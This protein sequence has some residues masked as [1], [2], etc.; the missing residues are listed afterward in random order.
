[1]NP[2]KGF[3]GHKGIAIFCKILQPITHFYTWTSKIMDPAE[4]LTPCVGFYILLKLNIIWVK[5]NRI[6]LIKSG[7]SI[8][9]YNFYNY[10]YS[11][12][13]TITRSYTRKSIALEKGGIK[14][15]FIL[16][17]KRTFFTCNPTTINKL[18]RL[19]SELKL[20]EFS[21]ISVKYS[22]LNNIS[23]N[24]DKK[25]IKVS[26]FLCNTAFL[27]EINEDLYKKRLI[28]YRLK[29]S[30]VSNIIDN[31]N[32]GKYN[33]SS[34]KS[35]DNDNIIGD[36]IIIEG[37][38]VILIFILEKFNNNIKSFYSFRFSEMNYLNRNLCLS[39][40]K[41]EWNDI[42]WILNYEYIKDFKMIHRKI[43]FSELEK[44][45]QDQKFFDILHKLFNSK[46]FGIS[47]NNSF[48]KYLFSNQDLFSLLLINLFFHHFDKEIWKIKD[49]LINNINI[50]EVS[51]IN[52]KYLSNLRYKRYYDEIII[53][54]KGSKNLA[55][56]IK[57]EVDALFESNLDLKV[58][59]KEK[60][61][62]HIPS[63]KIFIFNVLVSSVSLIKNKSIN[64]LCLSKIKSGKFS[65]INKNITIKKLKGMNDNQLVKLNKINEEKYKIILN[66]N[67]KIIKILLYN[68]GILNK[69]FKPIALR[70]FLN[71]DSY[72]IIHFY[73]EISL[74]IWC[75][76]C[77][78]DN[79]LEVLNLIFYHIK[80][81]LL[82]TL[83]AKHKSTIR[84]VLRE[85]YPDL[86]INKESKE[87]QFVTKEELFFIKRNMDKFENDNYYVNINWGDDSQ[88]FHTILKNSNRGKLF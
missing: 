41:S 4:R 71:L 42:N 21:L 8:N 12:G 43:I 86:R 54:I 32:R 60:S 24:K 29:E 81:S 80:W 34:F 51:S 22:I 11:K 13:E 31:I 84:N 6:F 66:A 64:S 45:I 35:E 55:L 61:L 36:N 57:K 53:G 49:N 58:I 2:Y 16:N 9:R 52:F 10:T 7:N 20:N 17:L 79:S 68:S 39:H 30:T 27:L 1:M 75:T 70:K 78:C 83:A 23:L 88:D 76:F 85:H 33:F 44:Y 62:V 69:K 72:Y 63:D 77:L 25:Y 47:Q 3:L 26:S 87:I 40:L 65:D 50:N 74:I 48:N 18:S 59:N 15:I 67:V 5:R 56:D 28:P 46:S 38:R 73:R 82:H 14:R 19:N 37:I